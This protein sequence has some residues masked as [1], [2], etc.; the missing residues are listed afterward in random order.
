[1]KAVW[2][3]ELILKC[4]VILIEAIML[5]VFSP[6]IVL[7]AWIRAV[8][9]RSLFVKYACKGGIAKR[10]AKMLAQE[11]KLRNFFNCRGCNA[12]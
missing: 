7:Y 8:V 11:L 6:L 5:A 4:I 10:D 2:I 9:F 1:M 12:R 3:L